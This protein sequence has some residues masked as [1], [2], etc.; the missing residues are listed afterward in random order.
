MLSSFSRI[1]AVLLCFVSVCTQANAQCSNAATPSCQVYTQCFAKYCPCQGDPD[2]YFER[3]GAAYCKSFLAAANF[4]E[5]GKQWRT[6][7]L[8]CLQESIVPE[9]KITI[10]PSACNCSK[11]RSFA[12]DSH[13]SC[14]T[15]PG[16]SICDLPLADV[17]EVTRII[18]LKDAL[19]DDGRK[20]TARVAKKCAATA[21]ED[22]RRAAWKAAYMLVKPF[23]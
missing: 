19:T 17:L 3:Y 22:G 11:M 15:Q 23:D 18:K 9:L 5:A 21:A 12:F 20:Q 13:V 6:K 10:P 7:T 14:Y 2:E 16:A 8:V 4:S 1:V